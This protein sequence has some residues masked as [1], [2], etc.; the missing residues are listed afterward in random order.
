MS[1]S[2]DQFATPAPCFAAGCAAVIIGCVST[3]GYAFVTSYFSGDFILSGVK[4]ASL[5][6]GGL[7]VQEAAVCL[8][9][10]VDEIIKQ[11]I[12]VV[13]GSLEWRLFPTISVSRLTWKP[14][15]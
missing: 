4:V 12:T 10:H 11:P 6:V 3:A 1:V 2:R 13:Y 5:N 8:A 14:H 9:R 15:C 7:T